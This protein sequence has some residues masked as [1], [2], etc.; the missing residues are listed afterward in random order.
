MAIKVV[1]MKLAGMSTNIERSTKVDSLLLQ[2]KNKKTLE[3]PPVF[4]MRYLGYIR[5]QEYG[6]YIKSRRTIYQ[7]E[8]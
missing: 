7:R 8:S 6:N 4:E 2:N 3:K 5:K 1:E